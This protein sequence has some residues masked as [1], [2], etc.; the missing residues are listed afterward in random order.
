VATPPPS[1][2]NPP[3]A[4]PTNYAGKKGVPTFT[5]PLPS[6]P[7]ATP[8]EAGT[9]PKRATDEFPSLKS[10]S[11]KRDSALRPPS[12]PIAPI[13][14]TD[15]TPLERKLPIALIAGGVV[16]LLIVIVLVVALLN[17]TRGAPPPTATALAA[18]ITPTQAVGVNPLATTV[19]TRAA[20][21]SE[22]ASATNTASPSATITDT[23][24]PSPTQSATDT[25]LPPSTSPATDTV[26]APPVTSPA[27]AAPTGTATKDLTLI[28]NKDQLVVVNVSD[29]NLNLSTLMFVQHAT[30]SA[31]DRSFA[32]SLWASASAFNE[33]D[34]LQPGVCFQVVR[35]G[36]LDL[37]DLPKD[38]HSRGAWIKVSQFRWFWVI[39]GDGL[40]NQFDVIFGSTR[41]ATCN[42][43]AGR[44]DISLSS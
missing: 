42:I 37:P 2:S 6:K 40:S 43:A 38:C 1:S 22:T 20:T 44:C 30:D 5:G 39:G 4:K 26:V 23:A 8:S 36:I 15:D 18:N 32:A 25:E 35:N 31:N 21:A 3:A 10:F 11:E 12:P 29:R 41:V 34:S 13:V 14:Q 27:T 16:A 28:Y 7:D 9:P 19:A 33:P 24:S 17:S